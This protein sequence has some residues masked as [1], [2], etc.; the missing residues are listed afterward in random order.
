MPR[1]VRVHAFGGPEVLEIEEHPAPV[2]GRGQVRLDIRAIG[3][4]RNEIAFRSGHGGPPPTFPAQIGFEAAG[5]IAAVGPNVTEFAPGERVAVI[6]TFSVWE[7]GLYSETSLAPAR[8]LVR[9]P[10][11]QSWTEAAATWAAFATAW[12]G[13]VDQGALSS[14]QMVL[15]TAASSS[16]GLAAI[17]MAQD[18]GAIP[19]ALTRSATKVEQ[20]R[21]AGAAAVIAT[22]TEVPRAEIMRLTDG[23]GANLAFDAVAGELFSSL[24]PSIRVGGRA[25]VYG[26]LSREAPQLPLFALLGR[27]LTIRGFALSLSLSDDSKLAAAKAAILDGLERGALRPTIARTFPFSDI[28]EA[29]RYMESG[30]QFGKIVV[31]V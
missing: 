23:R 2:P 29:H 8:A 14:A 21:H 13:L 11:E 15:I 19:I 30:A 26:G 18:L 28:A 7:Y 6:P 20:L 16:V 3:I 22:N 31:T 5:V 25:V 4:N 27:N 1:T 10:D 9:I 24:V 17:Q 12:V